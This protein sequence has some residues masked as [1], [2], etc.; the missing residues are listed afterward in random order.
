MIITVQKEDGE[1]R[2]LLMNNRLSTFYDCAKRMSINYFYLIVTSV[3][4][5]SS[6]AVIGNCSVEPFF[7]ESIHF[8]N[9]FDICNQN[10]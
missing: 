10:S 9:L 8:L 5:Y 3:T 7:K 2:H 1:E 4:L 6:F